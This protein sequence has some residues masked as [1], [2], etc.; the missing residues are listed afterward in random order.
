ME[1]TGVELNDGSC[2]ATPEEVDASALADEADGSLPKTGFSN[3]LENRIECLPRQ[4]RMIH[5]VVGPVRPRCIGA[6]TEAFVQAGLV[7]SHHGYPRAGMTGQD[8][9]HEGNRAGPEDQEVFAWLKPEIAD[10]LD[11]T[12]EGFGE[13]GFGKGDVFGD[14]EEIPGDNAGGD[15]DGFGIGAVEE[16]EVVAKVGLADPAEMTGQA[17]GGIG[18]NDPGSEGPSDGLRVDFGDDA[19]EF[20][21]EGAGWGEHAGVVT[22]AKD[23]EIG[24]AG[25]G[26][27]DAETEFTGLE[28]RRDEGLDADLFPTVEDGS[29]HDGARSRTCGLR[30][31]ANFPHG[32]RPRWR[33]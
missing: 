23:L 5:V 27:L 21:A 3:R 20:V 25:E 13:G 24:A 28:G 1:A 29:A 16:E 10:A 8:H 31:K 17:G 32:L 14:R 4:F 7:S 15:D 22:A 9:G 33:R 11:H 19:G 6:E 30:G 2:G 18:G 26:G 12:G